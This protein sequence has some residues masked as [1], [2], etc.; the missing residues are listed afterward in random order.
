MR[1]FP[2]AVALLLA[3]ATTR[4]AELGDKG[5]LVPD[6]RIGV[7]MSRIA[8]ELGDPV[9]TV[10]VDVSPEALYFVADSIGVGGRVQL[11]AISGGGVSDA[12][13]GIGPTFAYAVRLGPRATWLPGTSLM[14]R[15]DSDGTS[16]SFELDAPL[17][18]VFD[19]F[20]LGVGPFFEADIIFT[21]PHHLL[22][23]GDDAR[24]ERGRPVPRRHGQAV[25]HLEAPQALPP[26][27]VAIQERKAAH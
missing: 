9:T 5:T 15:P 21:G 2:I 1:N 22:L 11:Q 10:L 18:F 27:R 3:S 12:A 8:P 20:F 17:L 4:A 24:L 23:V 6:G 26:S 19:N 7:T 14:L 16:L 25:L 13:F